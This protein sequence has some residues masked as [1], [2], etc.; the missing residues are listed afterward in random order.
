MRR[1]GVCRQPP[2][3]RGWLSRV[4]LLLA[5]LLPVW[6]VWTYAY[7]TIRGLR[8]EMGVLPRFY[9]IHLYKEQT[10]RQLESFARY[11]GSLD[12]EGRLAAPR[13]PNA[14]GSREKL[15]EAASLFGLDGPLLVLR[16]DRLQILYPAWPEGVLAV[17]LGDAGYRK[18]LF[19]VV[20]QMAAEGL[21]EG[22]CYLG[23]SESAPEVN[24]RWYLLAASAGQKILCVFMVPEK[25]VNGAGDHLLFAQDTLLREA[26]WRFLMVSLPI[27]VLSSVW[28]GMLCLGGRSPRGDRTEE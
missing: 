7:A 6:A 17:I 26:V 8:D 18:A 19:H 10:R 14:G 27:V 24:P 12:Q 9:G 11:A 3:T 13:L 20:S 25:N 15:S 16:R 2:G 28:L 23:A 1:Q 5:M 22:F 21:S 4:A